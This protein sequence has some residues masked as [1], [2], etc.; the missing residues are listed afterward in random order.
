M[1]KDV[2][3]VLYPVDMEAAAPKNYHVIKAKQDDSTGALSYPYG[4]EALC[5]R[6]K[7]KHDADI[8]SHQVMPID[9]SRMRTFLA[10]KQNCGKEVCANC[11]K[12]FYADD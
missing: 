12:R 9:N 5:E 3:V 2:Y 6:W 10:E 7:K 4:N 8:K 11:V 1:L